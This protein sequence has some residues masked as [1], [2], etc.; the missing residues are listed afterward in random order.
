MPSALVAERIGVLEY[1]RLGEPH[2][3]VSNFVVSISRSF[4]EF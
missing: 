2:I 3:V 1:R 4:V